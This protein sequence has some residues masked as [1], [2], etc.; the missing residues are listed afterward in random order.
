MA[1]NQYINQGSS[2]PP[3]S[4]SPVDANTLLSIGS[5][6]ASQYGNVLSQ[7]L[8]SSMQANAQ[9][10]RLNMVLTETQHQNDL[11]LKEDYITTNQILLRGIN[12][13]ASI[14]EA[15]QKEE[16][17]KLNSVYQINTLTKLNTNYLNFL[18]EARANMSPDGN[19]YT[20]SIQ[21]FMDDQIKASVN[22]A[23]N[24]EAKFDI[25]TR[26]SEFKLK[27][28]NNAIEVEQKA[29]DSYRT[30]L[31][32]D[33]SNEIINQTAINPTNA[34][35]YLKD[36][37]KMS[38]TLKANG[39]NDSQ[40][41]SFI[42]DRTSSLREAQIK[43]L[44]DSGKGKLAEQIINGD[45]LKNELEPNQFLQLKHSV[46]QFNLQEAKQQQ[47][48][49]NLAISA[50]QF[51]NGMLPKGDTNFNKAA[52]AVSDNLLFSQLPETPNFTLNDI[53]TTAG[54][55]HSFFQ[56]YNSGIGAQTANKI[57]SKIITS[58]NVFEVAAYS[59]GIDSLIR[60]PNSPSL[61][62]M[63]GLNQEAK[64]VAG[65]IAQLTNAG[66]PAQEAVRTA[67]EELKQSKSNAGLK[68]FVDQ[69]LT[70]E[71]LSD[72]AISGWVDKALDNYTTWF[73]DDSADKY[74]GYVKDAY[75]GNLYKYGN[76]D[77]AQQATIAQITN[78]LG[79]TK[80]NG[81]NQ[82]IEAAPEMFYHD[83]TL[84]VFKT[85]LNKTKADMAVQFNWLDNGD[86]TYNT[87]NGRIK[88]EIRPIV[89]VTLSQPLYDKTYQ[90]ID[91]N[92]G[93][94]IQDPKTGKYATFRFKL[95][96][97][98]YG[99]SLI[100]HNDKL[101]KEKDDYN[102]AMEG[103]TNEYVRS[104]VGTTM[105]IKKFFTD[106]SDNNVDEDVFYAGEIKSGDKE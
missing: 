97:T 30:G 9:A 93:L 98:E 37:N 1:I 7:D 15:R 46:I 41:A 44:L 6:V 36:I 5:S 45:N 28:L 33:A 86:G 103:Y 17:K 2:V 52:D 55:I 92:S 104:L 51:M 23:P 90:L 75:K 89:D 38:S 19:G 81:A 27:A 79:V 83:D 67:R 32:V 16:E 71:A 95:D 40:V 53:P 106:T 68:T 60:D 48:K 102:K 3:I 11:K 96:E 77:L 13:I 21:T 76:P 70:Q 64:T 56:K 105:S 29:R 73:P 49:V 54:A 47:K 65:R 74:I 43:G 72:V 78:T 61:E 85:N 87:A 91:G 99:K 84:Y 4:S 101:K 42:K 26:A 10:K 82:V 14:D 63:K 18:N 57:E 66:I 59:I 34:D 31:L 50:E 58:S 88:P 69:N 12:S 8:Q 22:N 94:P 20:Q 35:E 39:F 80:V 62:V 25:Y 24:E 100:K